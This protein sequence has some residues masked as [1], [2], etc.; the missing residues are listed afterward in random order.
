MYE[1]LKKEIESFERRTPK[2]RPALERSMPWMPLGVSSNFRSYEPYPLF[3]E[4]AQGT[5]A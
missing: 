5:L 4:H 2:S 3:I 1:Q